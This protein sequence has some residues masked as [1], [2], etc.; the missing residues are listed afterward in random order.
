MIRRRRQCF[1][2]TLVTLFVSGTIIYKNIGLVQKYNHKSLMDYRIPKKS[3]LSVINSPNISSSTE[4]HRRRSFTKNSM[5]KH[6]T[7]SMAQLGK[8]DEINKHFLFL[9]S[10][11]KS[12]SEIL[13]FLLE[14]IQGINNFKHVRLKG[15]NRRKLTKVQ[16][17]GILL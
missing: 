10:V 2:T 17:V 1:L 14:K 16:Q 12:G 8:M 5:R 7:K 6:V 9:N 3:L 11:P 15:G 13:I 4:Y